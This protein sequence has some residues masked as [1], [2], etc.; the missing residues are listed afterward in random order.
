MK[1]MFTR[2][3]KYAHEP[4]CPLTHTSLWKKTAGNTISTSP[5]A[6]KRCHRCHY[7]TRKCRSRAR[8]RTL[9][10]NR[11]EKGFGDVQL[12]LRW[13][14]QGRPPRC[15]RQLQTTGS[16]AIHGGIAL[17]CSTYPRGARNSGLDGMRWHGR[18]CGTAKFAAAGATTATAGRECCAGVATTCQELA[19]WGRSGMYDKPSD[20]RCRLN[21]P[22]IMAGPLKTYRHLEAPMAVSHLRSTV[23]ITD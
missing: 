8:Y 19:S 5:A 20:R 2:W 22:R 12:A 16:R 7:L 17:E 9:Y 15:C 13:L 3:R 6:P 1:T 4:P 11:R 18:F 10:G 21:F 14:P 23:A